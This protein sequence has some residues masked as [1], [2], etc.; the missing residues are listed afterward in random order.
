MKLLF[1][2]ILTERENATLGQRPDPEQT[3]PELAPAGDQARQPQ[4]TKGATRDLAG[5]PVAHGGPRVR[6]L[7]QVRASKVQNRHP[8]RLPF[9]FDTS[10][11]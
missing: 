4:K 9:Y 2:S 10:S 3:T 5:A 1:Y 7:S 8:S 11:V 6:L